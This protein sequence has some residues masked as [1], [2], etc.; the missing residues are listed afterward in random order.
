MIKH[1]FSKEINKE[2]AQTLKT[3]VNDYFTKNNISKTANFRMV[4]KTLILITSYFGVFSIIL[5]SGITN[6]GLL[7]AMWGIFG[8]AA[9]FI[10][11]GVMHDSLH[12]SYSR[13]KFVSNLL[14]F[15]AYIVGANPKIWKIQHNVLHHSFTNIEHADDD[16]DARYVLRFSPFQKRRW[17]HRWQYVYAVFFYSL[18]TLIWITVKD[19]SRVVRYKKMGHIS[20]GKEFYG[21]LLIITFQK[22]AYIMLFLGLP[23]YLLPIA[24]WII[25]LMF[26]SSHMISGTILSLVF[27]CAHITPSA[28][29]FLQEEKE[30]DE[31]WSVHQLLTTSDF[32]RKNAVIGWLF[33]GLNFQIEHHLFPN[34]CHVHYS[35]ISPIVESTAKEFGVPYHSNQTFIGALYY[36]FKLLRDLGKKEALQIKPIPIV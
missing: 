6:I 13:N 4:S 23:L 19:F 27:Q 32:A 36:H 9:A 21:L 33:G 22:I 11:S 17:F 15:S 2:F 24:P 26:I 25:V 35:K 34:I 30:I 18:M 28:Q 1:T 14:S 29:F 7:F 16:I 31:N 8:L 10:G 12:G 20:K 3:R 5:F